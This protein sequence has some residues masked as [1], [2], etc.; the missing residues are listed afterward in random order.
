VKAREQALTPLRDGR[1]S[2][3]GF[4]ISRFWLLTV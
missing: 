3:A 4:R 2:L 1:T